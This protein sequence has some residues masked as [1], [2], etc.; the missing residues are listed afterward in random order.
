MAGVTRVTA[1][2]T[3]CFGAVLRLVIGP[4]LSKDFTGPIRSLLIP[5]T[6]RRTQLAQLLNLVGGQGAH[7]GLYLV[8]TE[9][10]TSEF[11]R[12]INGYCGN[13]LS[14]GSQVKRQDTVNVSAFH[15]L[16]G[17]LSYHS[18]FAELRNEFLEHGYQC[19]VA[20]DND[21]F[22]HINLWWA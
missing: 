1:F 21:R 8:H 15:H 9:F 2:P 18:N 14:Q 5:R 12:D 13:H 3:C 17:G 20:G 10:S 6:P 11:C 22:S 19:R 16:R 4:N 7:E